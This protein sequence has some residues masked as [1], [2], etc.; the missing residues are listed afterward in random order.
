MEEVIA[1]WEASGISVVDIAGV[2]SMIGVNGVMMFI[3]LHFFA[4]GKHGFNQLSKKLQVTINTC[5][6]IEYYKS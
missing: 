2:F 1:V 6:I 3:Y 5:I 4:K